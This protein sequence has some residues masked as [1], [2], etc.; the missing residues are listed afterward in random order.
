M[1]MIPVRRISA[2]LVLALC[3][4]LSWTDT[5]DAQ[6]TQN[7]TFRFFP[8][9]VG[10]ER[11]FVPGTF[12]G[13]GQPYTTG[14][15]IAP[16]HPSQMTFDAVNSV[17]L[18]TVPLTVGETVEY[19]FQIH[20]NTE[21]TNCQWFS[22]PLNPR[23]NLADN[24]NSVLTIADPMVFETAEEL[25]PSGRIKTFSTG[26]FSTST[27]AD[28]RFFVNGVEHTDGLNFYD[29][30]TGIFRF[31]VAQELR[32]GAQF[33][34]EAT[35]EMN[36]TVR[37]EIG[38]IQPPID[39]VSPPFSTVKENYLLI[40]ELT[41][42]DGTIDPALTE[43]TLIRNGSTFATVAVTNGRMETTV[44][45]EQGDNVFELKASLPEGE[46]TSATLTVSRRLPPLE[47]AFIS[48]FVSGGSNNVQV[49]LSTTSQAPGGVTT[50][51]TFD[52]QASTTSVSS[53]SMND[54]QA[55]AS[56]AGPGELY[57]NVTAT[58][59]D[60]ETD[61]MRVAV[62]VDDAGNAQQM[63]YEQNA[64]W[65]KNAVV[66]EI[67]PLSF[68]PRSS[69]TPT[70]PSNRLQQITQ[71]LDYI[72]EMG[73]T[74]IWF[75]PIMTN[76]SMDP[77]SGGYNITD[78]KTVDPNL[79]TNAD[80]KALVDRA[81][82]LGLHIIMDITPNH[83][84][85]VHP[86][87]Q[88]LR[89][90]GPFSSFIQ[91]EPN[92]HT[93]GLDDRGANLAEVWQDLGNGKRYRK[94]DGFGDLA[95]V[96]WADDDLQASM[97]EVFQFWVEEFGIDGW[98]FDV[99]WGP[100]RKWG[101][102]RF[103]V[104]IRQLMKRIR[105][106]A[107]LLGEIAG[108]GTN[109]EVYYADS[110]NG[111]AVV[112]GLDSGYDWEFF[113][114]GIRG[115][116]SASNYHTRA[117]LNGFYP[118]PNARPFRFLENHDETRVAKVVANANRIK[119]M[120]GFLLTT[121]GIPMIYQGQEVHFGAGSGDTRRSSVNWNTPDNG[122]FAR[123]HQRLAQMRRQFKAFGTQ[124]LE[125]LTVSTG[126]VYAAVRPYQDQ[127]AVVAINF[128]SVPQTITIDAGPSLKM[129]TDGPVPY[130]DLAADTV[131]S[132]LGGFS[133]TIPP[134]ETLVY[135]TSDAPGFVL[136]D[137]PQLPFGALYTGND[138]FSEIP[139]TVSLD[140]NYPNPFRSSTT[141]RYRIAKPSNV[142]LRVFDILGREVATV[143]DGFRSAGTYEAFFET[144]DLPVGMYIY[145]LETAGLTLSRTMI[146]LR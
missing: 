135:I 69:G 72:A 97:L 76:Q 124:D 34:I 100:W 2:T 110:A 87:V 111:K 127:N 41:R 141:I 115:S 134:Y 85:P 143:Y 37:D 21:G 59:S 83:V 120:T 106:D 79:G 80:F 15:C 9:A 86:W 28:I 146:L 137:L 144:Q 91:T 73:F 65:I 105:P 60:G 116:Y 112:G 35:D 24:G 122:E 43:A 58:R 118:G 26:L 145:R 51:W 44:V 140:Q 132:Y 121:T 94:Y 75:M 102:D 61:F 39:W 8:S 64:S 66:Y 49:L 23:L 36:R 12:N 142:R 55:T 53:L 62:L 109:T 107:W 11:A 78:L 89:N 95:N 30:T 38:A 74:A 46:F 108:T 103:G 129:S 3:L 13:W 5:V 47:R 10:G 71:E 40:A 63:R 1:R 84:S 18:L 81:H 16:G 131:A 33:I 7:V 98:R 50:S 119:V 48:A 31:P 101:P 77:I 90:G 128:A 130:Y 123:L 104:P 139:E 68:G 136:P 138:S 56:A 52:E 92:N 113:W 67:F 25:L 126:S 114:S 93:S 88:S 57:F 99:Y 82:E 27:L 54:L 42:L 20:F 4:S 6:A 70:N 133:V 117:F 45:L 19:K 14:S 29:T 96:N 22:D 17:L 125:R 32:A